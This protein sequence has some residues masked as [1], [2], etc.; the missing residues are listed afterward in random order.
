MICLQH[1]AV[2][3]KTGLTIWI[4]PGI[5]LLNKKLVFL[6]GWIIF[7]FL[8][9]EKY[10]KIAWQSQ[11]Q[12]IF[13]SMLQKK[14]PLVFISTDHHLLITCIFAFAFSNVYNRVIFVS[15]DAN[16]SERSKC[17]FD[18]KNC[19]T[20]CNNLFLNPI[21]R[22][23]SELH[24]RPSRSDCDTHLHISFGTFGAF[25]CVHFIIDKTNGTR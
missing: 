6:Q 4:I 2:S 18:T 3:I 10:I 7:I 17:F 25:Q 12:F 21:I 8:P 14:M 5:I 9:V 1:R 22:V 19:N 20:I 11:M 15:C 24:S 13:T 16:I 23:H